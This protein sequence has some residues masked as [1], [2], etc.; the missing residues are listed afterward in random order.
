VVLV[1]I[2]VPRMRSPMPLRPSRSM[3]AINPP[4]RAGHSIGFR[5]RYHVAFPSELDRPLQLRHPR[6]HAG[7]LAK[8]LLRPDSGQIAPLSV[9]SLDGFEWTNATIAQAHVP[10]RTVVQD[11]L[12]REP[13]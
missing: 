8:A 9:K 6:K 3:S 7:L 4:G 5:D 11:S 13:L 12:S 10:L 2:G 1:S